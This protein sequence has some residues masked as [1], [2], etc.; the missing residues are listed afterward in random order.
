[1]GRVDHQNIHAGLDQRRRPLVSRVPRRRRRL[2]TGRVRP[3]SVTGTFCSLSM[4]LIV[5]RPLSLYYRPPAEA[6]RP[7]FPSKSARPLQASYFPAPSPDYPCVMTSAMRWS[8]SARKRRSRRVRM[9]FR[10]PST[11]IGTPLM[12]CCS[13]MPAGGADGFIRRQRDRVGDDAVFAPLDL[14]HLAG[15]HGDRHVLVDDADAALLGERDGQF[16]LGDRVHRRREDRNVERILR[17]SE[18]GHRRRAGT[19]R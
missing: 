19:R 8:L 6:S 15:L 12:F 10:K 17:V 9:P 14:V 16:A 13:M 2:A 4:S 7:Y 18:C 3:C 5:I 11:V 1:M